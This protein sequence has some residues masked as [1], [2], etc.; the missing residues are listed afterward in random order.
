MLWRGSSSFIIQQEPHNKD[1]CM[2][3]KATNKDEF[4]ERVHQ[5]A[6]VNKAKAKDANFKF[7]GDGKG[8]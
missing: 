8:T 2:K 3:I 5:K 1:I 6:R 7:N 4:E